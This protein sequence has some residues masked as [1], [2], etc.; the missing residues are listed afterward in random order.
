MKNLIVII[1]PLVEQLFM[2]IILLCLKNLNRVI[3]LL[4][5]NIVIESGLGSIRLHWKGYTEKLL[6]KILVT[7]S[8]FETNSWSIK[9]EQKITKS[10]NLRLAIIKKNYLPKKN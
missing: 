2:L 6:K 8:V 9:T 1:V 7:G 5:L 4:N 10:N 3:K